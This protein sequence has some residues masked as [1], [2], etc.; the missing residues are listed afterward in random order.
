M[1]ESVLW[2]S[3]QGK[4]DKCKEILVSKWWLFKNS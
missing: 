3:S 4:V 1:H 2:L